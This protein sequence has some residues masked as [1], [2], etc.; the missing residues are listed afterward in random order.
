MTKGRLLATAA[1]LMATVLPGCTAGPPNGDFTIPTNVPT[2]SLSRGA[3]V[4]P[5]CGSTATG[6]ANEVALWADLLAGTGNPSA[7]LSVGRHV[8]VVKLTTESCTDADALPALRECPG[9]DGWVMMPRAYSGQILAANG[10]AEMAI[11][12]SEVIDGPTPGT[13][14]A[15][16]YGIPGSVDYVTKWLG[17]CTVGPDADRLS[18]VTLSTGVLAVRVT[19][20]AGVDRAASDRLL[21]QLHDR[22]AQHGL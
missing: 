4:D 20:A 17:T 2:T 19:T 15:V 14:T 13:V 3:S 10:V 18:Q 7:D 16:F 5:V 1:T 21:A 22:L 12:R 9:N 8:T 6:T 11:S